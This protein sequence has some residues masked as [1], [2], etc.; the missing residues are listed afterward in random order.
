M[1]KNIL[2]SLLIVSTG[3]L[4]AL[5]NWSL[6]PTKKNPEPQTFFFIKTAAEFKKTLGSAD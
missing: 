1:K 3:V 6:E 5:S 2:L 4:S